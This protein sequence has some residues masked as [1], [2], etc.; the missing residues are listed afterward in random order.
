ML[1]RLVDLPDD[2]LAAAALFHAQHARRIEQELAAAG[3]SKASKGSRPTCV[4][5]VFPPADH[6]HRGWRL[7]SVQML[8]RAL[9]P[10]RVNAVAGADEAGIAATAQWLEQAPGVTG[11]L[12]PLT[13]GL[14]QVV[15]S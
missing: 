5:L 11:Q 8:A 6:T 15:V 14:G 3:V 10:C 13:G 9:A 2:P 7:A 4:T 12:L 1:Y